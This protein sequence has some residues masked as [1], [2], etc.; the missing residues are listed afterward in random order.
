VTHS[1]GHAIAPPGVNAWNPAFDVTP[2]RFIA[3]I[4]TEKGI[5]RKPY[6][7]SLRGMKKQSA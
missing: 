6:R 2:N 1:L 3:G 5:A 7:K 4:I